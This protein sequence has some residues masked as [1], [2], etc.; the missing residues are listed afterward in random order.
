M[1]V[2]LL[3]S[4]I[5]VAQETMSSA[6]YAQ[7]FWE[8]TSIEGRDAIGAAWLAHEPSWEEV[9]SALKA[10]RQYRADVPTGYLLR[11]RVGSDGTVYPYL[12]LVPQDYDP[13]YAYP[14]QLMLHGGMGAPEWDPEKGDWANGWTRGDGR[15]MIFPA[16]WVDAMW[17]HRKQMDN[18]EELLR[19]VQATWHIDPNR[20]WI[21]GS[22]D[23]CAAIFFL[24]ARQPNRFAAYA[25]HVGPPDRLTR[26]NMGADGQVHLA[27]F[28][29]QSFHFGYGEKD[30]LVPFQFLQRYLKLFQD[31][32]AQI[33]WYS[34]PERGHE[35]YLPEEKIQ[36][37]YRF[38]SAARRDPLPEELQWAS[39][40]S[41]RYARRSWVAIEELGNSIRKPKDEEDG[42]LPRWGTALQLRGATVPRVPFGLAKVQRNGNEIAVET[43]N[44]KRLS[45]FFSPEEFDFKKEVVVQWHGETAFRGLLNGSAVTLLHWAAR[46]DDPH[47]LFPAT[48]TLTLPEAD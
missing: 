24:A 38:L 48:L 35:L 23:G 21:T 45:L 9:W 19:E 43:S 28:E 5:P 46:D 16:G 39:E 42:I 12:L 3:L 41:E 22:S 13:S 15:I 1:L 20:V 33:D 10:P 26:A 40:S 17:W 4:L 31:Y 18:L 34:L 37:M 36:D 27:N 8:C 6:E 7:Q 44:I 14:V 32:G 11:K 47:R 25:G 30:K 29:G 2:G